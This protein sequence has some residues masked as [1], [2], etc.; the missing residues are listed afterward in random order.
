M[1]LATSIH[2]WLVGLFF[3]AG[4]SCIV[5]EHALK[6]NKA[7]F[8]LLMAVLCW[9]VQ[10]M[11]PGVD[12][13]GALS[14]H[15]SNVSQVV[16]FLLGAL[17]I[18]EIIQAHNGLAV[19]SRFLS[20]SSKTKTLW[21]VGLVAFFLSSILDN[22]TTTIVMVTMLRKIIKDREDRLIF[23]AAVVI[24]AN[25]GGAWTPIGDV[26]TTMLWIGG[27]VSTLPIMKHLFIPSIA[28]TAAA[29]GYFSFL[30]RGTKNLTT[31]A[32]AEKEPVTP[33]GVLMFFLGMGALIAVP[34]IKLLTGLPPFM[35]MLFSLSTMWLITELIHRGVTERQHLRVTSLFA[36][37]DLSA[38]LFFLGILLS[39]A[40]L[41]TAGI[42]RN[43]ALWL[44]RA[45]ASKELIATI[46]GALSAIV[47]NV[48]LVAACIGMYDLSAYPPDSTFWQLIAFAVGTGG[49]MLIIGSAAGVG[50]MSLENVDF[51]WFLKKASLAALIGYIVGIAAILIL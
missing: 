35:G 37:I 49:S 33:L 20:L 12:N 32:H 6:I 8:A 50:F 27:Q 25:A 26:T 23:G 19:V 51:F 31:F 11:E 46:I 44:D 48:P 17:T 28:C 22:L 40:A 10:F 13:L 41:E 1:T 24:A 42:L 38:V 21:V 29:L 3:V 16:F 30:F 15:L 36:R 39:I 5:F 34:V 43:T 47:D 18:V 14:V 4:Y 9:T 45:F 7:T 2:D